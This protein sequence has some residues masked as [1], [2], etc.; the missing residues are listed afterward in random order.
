[1]PETKVTEVIF[2]FGHENIQATHHATLE[3][4]RDSHVSKNGD[5][6]IAISADKSPS[7]LS[8]EFKET[9]R[10][11]G[12]KLTI[13]VE[14]GGVADQVH[15]FGSPRLTLSHL[16][17]A[18]VRKSEFVSDR[19]LAVCADKAAKDLSRELAE[20]LK[21]PRQKVKITLTARA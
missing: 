6:I 21:N 17:E 9:L 19:T 1:L 7:D 5:C 3:F 16:T 13:T 8:V 2:A 10:K 20:K 15:A 14:A 4:T 18:V 12:A 11:P